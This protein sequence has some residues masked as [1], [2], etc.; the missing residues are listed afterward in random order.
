MSIAKSTGMS[1]APET[2]TVVVETPRGSAEKYAYDPERSAFVLR[3]VLP[4]GMVMPYDFGFV[5]DTRADDG[6][7]LDVIVLSELTSF[8]GCVMECRIIGAL[9]AEQRD[10]GEA[11]TIRNDRLI[12]IPP[13]ARLLANMKA[14]GD[15]PDTVLEELE[16]FF[17]NYHR[18]E[19][20]VFEPVG[21]ADRRKALALIEEA[22]RG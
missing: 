19:G 16:Q 13:R 21:R 11:R 2:T 6:D 8:P 3:K 1:K 22:R 10:E 5:P 17:V 4:T 20:G 15:V 9:L 7:P 14:I 18:L 12:A